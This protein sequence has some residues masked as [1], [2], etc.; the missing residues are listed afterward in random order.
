MAAGAITLDSELASGVEFAGVFIAPLLLPSRTDC[1]S[2]QQTSP[3]CSAGAFHP[4]PPIALD[5]RPRK[6]K[7]CARTPAVPGSAS[8]LVRRRTCRD[9]PTLPDSATPLPPGC[10]GK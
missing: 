3:R 1:P 6:E 5:P 8:A 2:P 4:G 7:C 10:D 9:G